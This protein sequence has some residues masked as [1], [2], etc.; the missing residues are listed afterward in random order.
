M[1]RRLR[2]SMRAVTIV[3]A[4][5]FG[6][7][8]ACLHFMHTHAGALCCL[9]SEAAVGTTTAVSGNDSSSATPAPRGVSGLCPVCLFLAG[10]QADGPAEPPESA[11]EDGASLR[12]AVTVPRGTAR[13]GWPS[14]TPRSPPL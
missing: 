7:L 6:G 5:W 10:Y 1:I 11:P 4:L 9:A 14:A 12:F 13:V 3:L 2:S 8:N